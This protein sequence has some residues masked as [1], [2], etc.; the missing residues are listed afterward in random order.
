[1][2]TP[3]AVLIMNGKIIQ[4][5]QLMDIIEHI[6]IVLDAQGKEVPKQYVNIE[7]I[8]TEY[9]TYPLEVQNELF[10]A[11]RIAELA[12]IYAK[13]VDAL[14]AGADDNE[15]FLGKLNKEVVSLLSE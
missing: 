10:K 12:F 13:R 5:N 11:R 8:S 4:Y 6:S 9:Y 1:M 15:A 14:F 2:G 7:G 3:N